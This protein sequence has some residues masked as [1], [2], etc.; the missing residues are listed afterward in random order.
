[1]KVLRSRSLGVVVVTA[2]AQGKREDARAVPS[3]ELLER[4]PLARG[5]TA[6]ERL[7]GRTGDHAVPFAGA[8]ALP[9]RLPACGQTSSTTRCRTS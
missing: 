6:Y 5:G 3:H 8:R 4:L 9:A 2:D 7:V 1:M